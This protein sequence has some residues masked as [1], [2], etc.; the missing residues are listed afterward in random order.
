[1]GLFDSFHVSR[2][3]TT[4]VAGRNGSAEV[5][6]ALGRLRQVGRSALPKIIAALPDDPPGDPLTTLLAEMITTAVLPVIVN[7]GLLNQDPQV[8]ARARY[9]LA[10]APKY[11]PNR[12]VELYAAGGGA[13][14]NL[15]EIIRARASGV[16]P[17]TVLR[18]LESAHADSQPTLFKL[19]SEIG[20]A[21]V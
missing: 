12:L 17:K 10:R 15:A 20:R 1:M 16:T 21:H 6:S 5:A 4:I 11:D 19:V 2:A 14:V 8:V 18:L 9:A 7:E 13:L 3:I